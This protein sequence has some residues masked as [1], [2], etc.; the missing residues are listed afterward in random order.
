MGKKTKILT[1]VSIILLILIC[2]GTLFICWII[3]GSKQEESRSLDT[4]REWSLPERYS[5]LL[6][7]PETAPFSAASISYLYQ[8]QEGWN[9]PM[10]QLFLACTLTEA[11]F[12]TEKQRL[13]KITVSGKNGINKAKYDEKSFLYPA[14]VAIEGYDFCYE[15]A[16]INESSRQVIYVYVMNTIYRDVKFDRKYLPDYYMKD[17]ENFEVD[18]LDRFTIYG[19]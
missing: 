3:R 7:F 16:L 12:E 13:S 6:I 2:F 18:G 15:Y 4:Y 14:Y 5:E 9:R 10:C 8:F 17:F 19:S 1:S 11:E